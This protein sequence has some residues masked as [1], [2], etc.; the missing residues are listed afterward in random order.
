MGGLLS[1]VNQRPGTKGPFVPG[2]GFTRD[3]RLPIYFLPP[4]PF[5]LTLG[6]SS[7]PGAAAVPCSPHRASRA[8][9]PPSTSP[10]RAPPRE[11][12]VPERRRPHAA[13]QS[14]DQ[15]TGDP[16]EHSR[17]RNALAAIPCSPSTR[18]YRPSQPT[19]R[20]PKGR[21]RSPESPRHLPPR[22]RRA[23]SPES[24]ERRRGC[25]CERPGTRLHRFRSFQGVP[26]RF[27][28]LFYKT[29]FKFYFKS[30]EL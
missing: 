16:P 9:P 11:P 19:P 17:R 25:R 5:P 1:R 18:R 23:C 6:F 24:A 20:L 12:N 15:P 28:G 2:G 13:A 8:P 10:P 4:S 29:S 26:A 21:A 27:Q 30:S 14:P 3:K 7:A 22:P